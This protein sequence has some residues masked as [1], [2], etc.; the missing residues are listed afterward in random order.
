MPINKKVK[1][2]GLA[3]IVISAILSIT[4]IGTP[5]TLASSDFQEET[6]PLDLL[7]DE[8]PQDEEINF[9]HLKQF[10]D[11]YIQEH[12]LT[13]SMQWYK[14][15]G[16]N[17]TEITSVTFTTEKP[18]EYDEKW[19]AGEEDSKEIMGYRMG[20]DVFIV[21]EKIYLH[22]RSAYMF[23]NEAYPNLQQINGLEL[24]DTSQ[25]ENMRAMFQGYK[26]QIEGI[27]NWD[28]SS[29]KYMEFMF[30][31]CTELISLD[32]ANW[33][34]RSVRKMSAMFQSSGSHSADM[35]LE[36]LDLS[37]WNTESL[38]EM[39]H[40]FYGCAKLKE[41]DLAHWN[42]SKVR[43]FSHL[44]A[45]CYSLESI[46]MDNW[47]TPVAASFDAMFNDCHSL[48]TLDISMLNTSNA[49]MFSQMFEA[50]TSLEIIIGIED[51]D[52]SS[53]DYYAFSETF[54]QCKSLQSLDL[55]KWDVSKADNMARMFAYCKNLQEVN[56]TG[57][58]I[59]SVRT[60][61]EMCYGSPNI[62]LVG[63]EEWNLSEIETNN[64]Y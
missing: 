56:V 41:L 6:A 22:P 44:F 32:I 4:C 57:W 17:K 3:V 11:K 21:G 9:D 1:R 31:G 16:L 60:M 46:R 52:V 7:N 54:H 61:L 38:E 15:I 36:N 55:S 13:K 58:D 10:K 47:D 40:M 26:G 8:L 28:V 19:I 62:K 34:V 50:C 37:K 5:P 59:S 43:D 18:K 23:Y 33:D 63:A 2:I 64:M 35:K 20:T 25:C 51:M 42:V 24:I 48:T 14:G 29:V 53:A 12:T 27:S 39:S 49:C 30:E 45:D